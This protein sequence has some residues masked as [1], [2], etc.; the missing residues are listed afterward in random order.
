[1]VTYWISYEDRTSEQWLGT[2]IVDVGGDLDEETADAF[3]VRLAGLGL[4]PKPTIGGKWNVS[5]QKLP[6]HVAIPV[7]YKHRLIT[8]AAITAPLGGAMVSRHGA[9]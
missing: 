9:N 2:V 3:V 1:M 7:E 8:D 4:S 6:R 5:F